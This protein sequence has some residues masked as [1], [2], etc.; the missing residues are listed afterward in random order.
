MLALSSPGTPSH[1]TAAAPGSR[2][3]PSPAPPPA[4]TAR[5]AAG[6]C[7]G[8]G[9]RLRGGPEG[10]R[11]A[12]PS[13]ACCA[14]QLA[15]ALVPAAACPRTRVQ[16]QQRA[17][18]QARDC[19]AEAGVAEGCRASEG[20][21]WDTKQR[22]RM[23]A[24]WW[25]QAGLPTHP[26]ALAPAPHQLQSCRRQPAVARGAAPESPRRAVPAAACK[27]PA[28]QGQVFG[29][30]SDHMQGASAARRVNQHPRRLWP[31]TLLALCPAVST[32]IFSLSRPRQ[33]TC[34]EHFYAGAPPHLSIVSAT[35]S[36]P[37]APPVQPRSNSCKAW[38]CS[39]PWCSSPFPPWS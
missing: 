19:A 24:V 21:C 30:P 28:G 11:A 36:A 35:S 8:A 4:G 1:P 23:E 33:S 39:S 22:G 17:A 37:S 2:A 12:A 20:L 31:H 26:A 14:E 3:A 34:V 25:A 32:T 6:R 10:G 9:R 5:T 13:R 16:A 18:Q 7:P 29:W 38:C 15:H 27:Y